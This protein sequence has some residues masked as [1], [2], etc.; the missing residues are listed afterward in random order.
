MIKCF[1]GSFLKELRKRN[2]MTLEQL[3]SEISS[4]KGYVWELE[5]EKTEP[6]FGAAYRLSR[7]LGVDMRLFAKDLST[8]PQGEKK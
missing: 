8:K 7:V 1:D 6:S 4:S 3:A 5:N 2:E